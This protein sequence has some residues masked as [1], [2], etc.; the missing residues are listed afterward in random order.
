M[1]YLTLPLTV[2][3]IFFLACSEEKGGDADGGA[4][5][6]AAPACKPTTPA[7]LGKDFFK[8]ISDNSGIRTDNFDPNPSQTIPINDHSRLAFADLD[9]DGNDDIVMHSLYPNPQKGIPFEHLVFLGNGDGTF[10]H[11]SDASGLRKVQAGF[12]AF[13][14]V[15]NDG[16]LDAFAGLD[17]QLSGY[18]SQ[19]LLN[20][21]KGKF[22]PRSGAGVSGATV[23]GNAVFGDFNGDARLDLYV[24]RGH[25]SYAAQD[26]LYFGN[27]DGSFVD[28]SSQLAGNASRASN[29]TVACDYDNDGDLD[30]FVSVYGVSIQ[31]GHNLL[32][33]NDGKGNFKDVAVERGFAALATGNYWLASTGKGTTA[34]PGKVPASY[35]GSNGFGL[36]CVDVD[37]DGDLDL[38]V[39]AISHPN[40]SI[41]SRKWSDPS[42]LLVNQGAARSFAFKN[43]FLERKI[44][45]NEGDVDG[46]AVDFDNDGLMDLSASRERK[47]ESAY[48]TDEQKGWFG[49]FQQ[50]PDGSFTSVGLQSGI[51]DMAGTEKY[52]RMKGAQNHAWSDVDRDGDLDLLVGG[53][54]TSSGRPN[55]LFQNLAG[56]KNAWLGVRLQGDGQKV[57]RDALGGR[58]ILKFADG[59][60]L[61]REKQSSRGMYNSADTRVLH[62]GL[63]RFGCGYTV[64]VRWP[65]GKQESFSNTQV[66]HN[67]ITTI[68]YG[69]G[70]VSGK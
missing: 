54:G 53:R 61:L 47:Y 39:T 49:L 48:T 31:L 46:A 16:D 56:S 28:K 20:D 10:R 51:N 41:Y 36:Q 18:T 62:F 22:T 57:N 6:A 14:D 34:E 11:A 58:V 25:T 4:P 5:D 69:Q 60:L 67:R 21:G 1:R 68:R 40:D 52:L 17:I 43:E 7:A 15:D 32:F 12:F 38:Y 63:A 59:T 65:D 44:P 42:V 37:R 19:I 27:G 70:V 23:A 35:V 8:D 9:G 30:V 2:L 3:W 45:F 13:G 29:G 64:A 55:F 33:E 24:G 26:M 66:P 50:Q